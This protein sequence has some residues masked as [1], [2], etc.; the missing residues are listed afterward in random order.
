M[1]I[2]RGHRFPIGFAAAFQLRD[3]AARAKH[4]NTM[5]TPPRRPQVVTPAAGGEG[6]W[7]R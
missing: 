4:D 6:A 5:A 3:W 2:P 1:A 7:S